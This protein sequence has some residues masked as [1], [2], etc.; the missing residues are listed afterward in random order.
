MGKNRTGRKNFTK[1]Q[2]GKNFDHWAI[3]LT[4]EIY[5]LWL[6]LTDTY[7]IFGKEHFSKLL[8]II[9]FGKDILGAL[10]FKLSAL[11]GHD[12]RYI[13]ACV[14]IP[15][16]IHTVRYKHPAMNNTL[17]LYIPTVIYKVL[18]SDLGLDTGFALPSYDFWVPLILCFIAL[19]YFS[20]HHLS[21]Q[22]IICSF[23]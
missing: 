18:V 9:L 19:L 10:P 13:F 14:I 5:S 22:E 4:M 20:S 23:A 21:L 6:C 2:E 3:Y 11:G 16:C 12:K 1:D 15:T 7:I 17:H 8:A